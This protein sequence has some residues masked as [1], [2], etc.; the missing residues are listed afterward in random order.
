[1]DE[2]ELKNRLKLLFDEELAANPVSYGIGRESTYQGYRRIDWPGNR[3]VEDR[4]AALGIYDLLTPSARTLDIG[5]NSGFTTV[6]AALLGRLAHGVEPNPQLVRIGELVAAHLG[7]AWKTAFFD[8][9]FSEF[10]PGTAYDLV[11]S[12]A[13]FHTH[14]RRERESALAYFGK[15]SECTAPGGKL[16]FESV[17]YTGEDSEG[18]EELIPYFTPVTEAVKVIE[19]LFSIER[20]WTVK[21]EKDGAQRLYVVAAKA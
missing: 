19:E 1:M 4:F 10:E 21:R 12:L 15:I 8:M 16:V 11:L 13:S 6:E 18:P 17:S 3:M 2:L 5:S 14:D 20:R 9:T 7:V